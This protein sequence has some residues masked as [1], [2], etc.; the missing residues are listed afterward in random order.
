MK[1][2]EKTG[3]S[4][5]ET[6]LKPL[7]TMELVAKGRGRPVNTKIAPERK[8]LINNLKAYRKKA[9]LTQEMMA[10]ILKCR[11]PQI[12][13]L[14]SGVYSPTLDHLSDIAKKL[15]VKVIDLIK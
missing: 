14:E 12:S 7:K 2:A 4:Q 15:K 8:K 1:T 13:A 9:G 3:K 5:H 10:K 11:Q 6:K